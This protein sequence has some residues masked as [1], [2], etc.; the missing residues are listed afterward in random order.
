MMEHGT[1]TSVYY[2]EGVPV[3][4][5]Q[6]QGRVDNQDDAVP[7][8]RQHHGMFLVPEQGQRVQMLNIEDQRF[9]VGILNK[10]KDFDPPELSEGDY[11][12][13]LD[14]KTILSFTENDDGLYDL[15]IEAS[16]DISVSAPKDGTENQPEDSQI[17]ILTDGKGSTVNVENQGKNGEINVDA[18]GDESSI[19][20]ENSGLNG[21]L[22]VKST[23]SSG[24]LT[25]K[26]TGGSS[27]INVENSGS[28]GT[29]TVSASGSSGSIT[30]SAPQGGDISVDGG[31]GVVTLSTNDPG[32][33]VIDGIDFDEH[34]HDYDDSGTT[35]TT[36]PP[37]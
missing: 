4:S 12:F 10:G 30:V 35:E 26:A 16:G 1:V 17:T 24:S 7:V 5:V 3:C 22:D 20:V 25:V 8:M 27:S 14:E 34:T 23:G 18:T 37:N 9:I 28:S 36:D 31:D 29:V 11:A 6:L 13:K 19:A 15:D 2:E 33:V 32:N 21:T